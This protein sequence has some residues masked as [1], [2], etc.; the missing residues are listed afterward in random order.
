VAAAA[1]GVGLARIDRITDF[2]TAHTAATLAAIAISIAAA[3]LVAAVS[4]VDQRP[5]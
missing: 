4:L 1:T 2:A 3:A 5:R